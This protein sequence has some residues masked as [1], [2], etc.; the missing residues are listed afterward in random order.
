M[1]ME[2]QGGGKEGQKERL[3]KKGLTINQYNPRSE[4]DRAS[5]CSRS[6]RKNKELRGAVAQVSGEM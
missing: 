5:L 3:K 2:R 4:I 6:H 1:N